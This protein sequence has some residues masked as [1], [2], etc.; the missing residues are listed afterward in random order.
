MG[1][2]VIDVRTVKKIFASKIQPTPLTLGLKKKPELEELTRAR[3]N[4][5]QLRPARLLERVWVKS[6]FVACEN[7]EPTRLGSL[8]LAS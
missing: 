8:R 7:S 5:A 3:N 4:S 2:Q 6:V 1:L